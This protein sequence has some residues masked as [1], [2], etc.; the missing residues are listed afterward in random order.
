MIY[1]GEY[2]STLT[3]KTGYS[4]ESIRGF[5]KY[6]QKR[7]QELDIPS[8]EDIQQRFSQIHSIQ[9]SERNIFLVSI[10]GRYH[11]STM[12]T[13]M[14]VVESENAFKKLLSEVN[15]ELEEVRKQ[16][17]SIPTH[18]KE[19]QDLLETQFNLLGKQK[20]LVSD[21]QEHLGSETKEEVNTTFNNVHVKVQTSLYEEYFE[22][23]DEY[24]KKLGNHS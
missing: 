24:M 14:K 12:I 10:V 22:K 5:I 17:E 23:I 20:S 16:L 4:E 6:L 3:K 2:I 8:V 7:M 9:S 15:N 11:L 1:L 19:Y 13:L 21:H 18:S